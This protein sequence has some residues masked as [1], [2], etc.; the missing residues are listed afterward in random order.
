MVLPAVGRH[1]T[2]TASLAKPIKLET[3]DA[4][5]AH[6]QSWKLLPL[7][8]TETKTSYSFAVAERDML[9][10]T[11]NHRKKENNNYNATYLLEYEDWQIQIILLS[12]ALL[13][14]DRDCLAEVSRT[15]TRNPKPYTR[16]ACSC[17]IPNTEA[18]PQKSA[19]R[20]QPRHSRGG[21]RC[22]RGR[23][24][25]ASKASWGFRDVRLEFSKFGS[26]AAYDCEEPTGAEDRTSPKLVFSVAVYARFVGRLKT[27]VI[28]HFGLQSH[29]F[30][31]RTLTMPCSR[32]KPQNLTCAQ[33]LSQKLRYKRDHQAARSDEASL[34]HLGR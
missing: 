29:H 19:L 33:N 8:T 28:P 2:R 1:H 16:G 5:K 23:R 10:T 17:C 34:P 30:Q 15:P 14:R 4:Q 9:P 7:P 32:L 24:A 21:P 31:C 11:G 3:F 27:R 12:C 25:G 20:L 18:E 6:Q 13:Q 22:H 26:V